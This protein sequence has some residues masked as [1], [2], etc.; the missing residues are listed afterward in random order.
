MKE[1]LQKVMAHAGVASRRKSEELMLAGNVSVNGRIVRELGFKVDLSKDVIKVN[2]KV[3]YGKEAH[4]YYL[5]HKPKNYVTT[6]SDEHGRKTVMDLLHG[7]SQRV[8]PVGRLDY[9]SEGL[10]IMTNDGAI[11]HRLMHPSYHIRKFYLVEVKGLISDDAVIALRAGV[12]L[13]DGKTSP[14]YVEVLL[15]DKRK[16]VAKVIIHEGRNRQVRRMFSAVGLEV[17]RLTRTQI[18]PIKLGNLTCGQFRPLTNQEVSKLRQA[19]RHA[20]KPSSGAS[21]TPVLKSDV[22]TEVKQ[23]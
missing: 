20:I 16:S 22:S 13:E 19:M 4:V 11:A 21:E 1:R 14:A 9:D 18:G 8:Y 12:E 2:G 15:H 3:I 17:S 6:A 10:V 23:K 5:V 7:V